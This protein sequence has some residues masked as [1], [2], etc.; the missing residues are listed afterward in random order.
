MILFISLATAVAPDLAELL[1][2]LNEYGILQSVNASEAKKKE[3]VQKKEEVYKPVT[4]N[5]DSLRT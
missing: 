1:A 4:L 3:E 5:Q 2:K